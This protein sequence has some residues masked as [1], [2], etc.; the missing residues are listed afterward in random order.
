MIS[1]EHKN[2]FMFQSV[3][4]LKRT[5]VPWAWRS[6]VLCKYCT[7]FIGPNQLLSRICS[8]YFSSGYS[9]CSGAVMSHSRNPGLLFMLDVHPILPMVSWSGC[10]CSCPHWITSLIYGPYLK[11][12]LQ[13]GV[14]KQSCCF[15][16]EFWWN[17]IKCRSGRGW[18]L[19]SMIWLSLV[20]LY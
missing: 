11:S 13:L 4:D 8:S 16:C 20:Y 10:L 1:S 7:N 3:P 5:F 18:E 9:L 15:C 17:R 14:N 6:S 19:A 12:Y 2:R